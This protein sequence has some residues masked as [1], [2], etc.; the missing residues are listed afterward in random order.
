M[1]TKYEKPSDSRRLEDQSVS[2]NPYQST[3]HRQLKRRAV[4]LG[5]AYEIDIW[6]TLPGLLELV[7]RSILRTNARVLLESWRS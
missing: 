7:L 5:M 1:T 2:W 4:P 3:D 6:T